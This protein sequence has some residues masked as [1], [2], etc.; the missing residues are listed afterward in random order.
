MKTAIALGTFDGVHLGHKAV[1]EA[2]LKSGFK[3]VAVAFP[4]P[5]KSVISCKGNLLTTP[6]KK[7]EILKKMGVNEVFYL[8]FT[9]IRDNSPEEFLSFLKSE[10]NPAVIC[11]GFNYRFGKNGLGDTEY[12]SKFCGENNIKSVVVPPVLVGSDIVSSTAIR[13]M[14]EAG[15]V[16]KAN[17]LL[18]E[19]FGFSAPVIKGDKRGRTI[20]FPTANQIYPD[21]LIKVKF[22]V[23]KSVITF[24]GKTYKGITNI[25]VRPSFP[26]GEISAE[27]YI[28]DFSGNLYDKVLDI[29]LIEFIRPEQ[30]FDSVEQLKQKIEEDIKKAH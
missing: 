20:G 18:C 8:D 15:E 11:C 13:E 16:L 4:E 7:R 22:G 12:L 1:I 2:S 6:I 28:Y 17:R 30:K 24:N 26:N 27:T 10:F 3:S 14:L 19:P 29:C 5:P 25:G 23:Y 21:N 9:E